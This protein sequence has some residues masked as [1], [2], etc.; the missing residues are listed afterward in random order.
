MH[1]GR[2]F[3]W[4]DTPKEC[5]MMGAIYVQT[6]VDRL[7]GKIHHLHV[8]NTSK[9]FNPKYYQSDDKVRI[10]TSEKWLKRLINYN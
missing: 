4:E 8:F 3:H 9:L 2:I 6:I 7:K 1:H 10:I 5:M